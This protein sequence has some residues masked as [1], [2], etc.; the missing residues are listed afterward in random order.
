MYNGH[1][2]RDGNGPPLGC[3]VCAFVPVSVMPKDFTDIVYLIWQ[4]LTMSTPSGQKEGN[5]DQWEDELGYLIPLA[6][7]VLAILRDV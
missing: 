7:S 5:P 3:S 1:E 2:H 6:H 4:L